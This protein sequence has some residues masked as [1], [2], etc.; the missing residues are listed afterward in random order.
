MKLLSVFSTGVNSILPI[1]L[2]MLFG[3]VLR[4]RGFLSEEFVRIGNKLSFQYLLPMKLFLNA[5]K[6]GK[7]SEIPWR[8]VLFCMLLMLAVFFLGWLTVPL[9]TRDPRR[10]G[11][12]LQST[13]RS[14]NAIIGVTLAGILGGEP[15]EMIS[16][17]MTAVFIPLMNTLAVI[18]LT[19]FL[20]HQDSKGSLK[21]VLRNVTKNPLI[22]GIA[23]GL[24]CV[25]IREAEQKL[26][27][28]MVFTLSGNLPFFYSAI[29]QLGSISTVFALVVLGGQFSFSAAG[30]MKREIIIGTLWR[31][32]LAPVFC[33]GAVY[34]AS[35]H[36]G[37]IACTGVE[38]PALVSLFAT[39]AAVSSAV[40]AGQM[41]NDEQLAT[42]IV[43]WT[44]V[45]SIVTLFV[46]ICTLIWTGLI[47]PI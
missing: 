19:I 27:G 35:T 14:N 39:P 32:V 11:V 24:G 37:L 10:K 23:L 7:F 25:L 2:L 30:D 17:I 15:A 16:A 1:V 20:P 3:F 43:V 34:L 28:R 6:I 4:Q 18:S 33:L 22:R 29:S 46:I 40:M 41:G 31:N 26:F 8:L 36:T 47:V 13:F 5:Y 12:L 44:S 45:S 9:G 38:Y 42:Q 21:T